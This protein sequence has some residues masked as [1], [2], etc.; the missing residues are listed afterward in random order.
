MF[1]LVFQLNWRRRAVGFIVGK[2]F[3]AVRICLP[4]V[5]GAGDIFGLFQFQQFPQKL[6]KT[7]NRIARI[8]FDINNLIGIDMPAA[9]DIDTAIDQV[10][11]FFLVM[12]H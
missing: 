3:S 6:G 5:K 10:G 1:K 12:A 2:N 7:I 8:A 11:V 9:K 4:G